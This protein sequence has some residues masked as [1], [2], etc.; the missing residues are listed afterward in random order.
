MADRYSSI[1]LIVTSSVK[2]VLAD[3]KKHFIE[4]P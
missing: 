1:T 4:A 3:G 2:L